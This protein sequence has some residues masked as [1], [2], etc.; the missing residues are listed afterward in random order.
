MEEKL[1]KFEGPNPRVATN[2]EESSSL[3]YLSGAIF[4][5]SIYLYNKRTFRI[6]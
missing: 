6:D 3:L 2:V 5:G 4:I 1:Y